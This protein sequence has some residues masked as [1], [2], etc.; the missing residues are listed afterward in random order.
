MN[1]PYE[2]LCGAAHQARLP[3]VLLGGLNVCRALGLAGIPVIIGA[4]A[5]EAAF[6][7]RYCCGRL[8]LPTLYGGDA[9]ALVVAAGQ[10]LAERFGRRLPLFYGNDDWQRLVQERRA[11]LEPHYLLLLNEPA[12]ANALIEK[13]RFQ[14]LAERRGLPVPRRLEWES[15]AGCDGPV[16]VKPRAK[17]GFDTSPVYQ[18]LFG[19]KGKAR[20]FA[21]GRALLAEPAARELRVEL[22]IQEY[23]SGADDAIFSFHGFC[24]EHGRVLDWFVG[25]KIRTYPALTG[26][27]T[28][29]ALARDEE[30]AALGHAAAAALPL[31]G[32]FKIDVKRD[33]RS[34][35]LHLLEVNARCNL[36]HYLGAANGINLPLTAYEYLVEGKRPA[37]PRPYRTTHRWL[38]LRYDW[39]AYRELSARGTL[40]LAGWLATLAATPKVY[41]LFAW[42]D[43]LPFLHKAFH[44][45]K[46]RLPA[47][48]LRL[49]R[50]LSAAS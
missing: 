17:F 43:P 2:L 21:D 34:G 1:D 30:V 46:S 44:V 13:D 7:S 9:L 11:E 18:R 12:V 26:I 3:A 45:A 24:D 36:W 35:R 33:T 23:V 49:R 42:R 40:G 39:R 15:L 5:H 29:L 10:R 6:A 38:Y 32:V 8:R 22:V 48:H 50:W 4:P 27:S 19:R 37:A 31:K 25:R 41:Q 28:Y 20:I 47:L 16:L 14:A